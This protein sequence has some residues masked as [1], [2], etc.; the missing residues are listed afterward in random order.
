MTL[1]AW[2]LA[3]LLA[4]PVAAVE[5]NYRLVELPEGPCQAGPEC[6]PVILI[7]GIHGSRKSGACGL[8]AD[9]AMDCNWAPL[10]EYLAEEHPE[11]WRKLH[12]YVF[13]YL[14]DRGES[15]IEM[16]RQLRLA[17][18]RDRS[19]WSNPT[20]VIGQSMGGLVAR[21]LLA[22]RSHPFTFSGFR[23]V[24][25]IITLAT[26]HHGTPLANRVLRNAL[27]ERNTHSPAAPLDLFDALYWG[28]SGSPHL[29]HNAELPN[30]SDLLWDD[31][32]GLFAE[33]REDLRAEDVEVNH[34]L[35]RLNCLD[36]GETKLVVYGGQ[37]YPPMPGA[38]RPGSDEFD[39]IGQLLETAGK[40][41]GRQLGY[42]RNDGF[43]PLDSALFSDNPRVTGRRWFSG[44]DHQDMMGNRSRVLNGYDFQW[45]LLHWVARDIAVASGS[46]GSLS[47]NMLVIPGAGGGPP[48]RTSQSVG[49]SEYTK[50]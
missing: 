44:Y 45:T 41:L 10:F 36:L 35:E 47:G 14:A 34:S 22:H 2:I 42:N 16:G 9:P 1:G 13:R 17:M 33:V 5:G 25:T 50:P 11:L 7:H 40:L 48:K 12:I 4:A 39:T 46:G 19:Y 15:V 43:V 32:D 30:R 49:R 27:A 31:Y 3:L 23:E 8:D 29:A 38:I 37:L 6:V 24:G 21:A 18:E 20:I 28:W 26:P